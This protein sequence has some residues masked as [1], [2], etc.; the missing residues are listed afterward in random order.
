M[1]FQYLSYNAYKCSTTFR[2]YARN[3][4]L[5]K[6][7]QKFHRN[8]AIMNEQKFFERGRKTTFGDGRIEIAWMADEIEGKVRSRANEY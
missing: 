1:E 8:R 5:T 3:I 2:V 4:N 7:S 6:Q